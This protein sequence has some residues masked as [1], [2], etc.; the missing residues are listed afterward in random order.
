MTLSMI[1]I[2]SKLILK[3]GCENVEVAGGFVLENCACDRDGTGL[4]WNN[5][6]IFCDKEGL[7]FWSESDISG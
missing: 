3:P 1:W 5:V 4:Y 6:L 7:L 2:N